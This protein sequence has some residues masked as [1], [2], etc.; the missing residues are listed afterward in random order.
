MQTSAAH[1]TL[2]YLNLLPIFLP[3]PSA[4]VV[5]LPRHC[6]PPYHQLVVARASEGTVNNAKPFPPQSLAPPPLPLPSVRAASILAIREQAR[7][8]QLSRGTIVGLAATAIAQQCRGTFVRP[9]PLPAQKQ[10]TVVR[11][12]PPPSHE[13]VRE[14]PTMPRDC[15]PPRRQLVVVPVSKGIPTMTR[16]CKLP[17]R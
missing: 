13:Q 10:A 14:R 7:D 17:H 16:H 12:P 8:G 2:N 3:Q 4:D 15:H 5:C 1:P 11:P 6:C 9:P